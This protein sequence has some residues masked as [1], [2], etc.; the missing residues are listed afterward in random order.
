MSKDSDM[1]FYE[2]W[3]PKKT[4]HLTI[5]ASPSYDGLEDAKVT[6]PNYALLDN[7]GDR[8]S[9]YNI[10]KLLSRRYPTAIIDL[11]S[12]ESL[13]SG[14]IDLNDNL[15]II[16]GPGGDY[17]DNTENELEGNIVCRLLSKDHI[18]S[19]I[20]YS[21]DCEKMM[22]SG[23][24]TPFQS[25]YSERSKLMTLDYGYFS[26]FKN[27][28]YTKTRVIML[29]GIHTLGVLGATRIFDGGE[30][31][32]VN[33]LISLKSYLDEHYSI[34]NYDFETFFKVK[35]TRGWITCPLLE[36]KN[37][38]FFNDT[39][40]STNKKSIQENN[41]DDN[42]LRDTVINLIRIAKNNTTDNI[43]KRSHDQLISMISLIKKDNVDVLTKI[44]NIC[45]KNR[46]IPE[47]YIEEIKTLLK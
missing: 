34:T 12:S 13:S 40:S 18:K 1:F 16:G 3:F 25:E 32:S 5:I 36:K 24:S 26:A 38:I 2:L 4:Q 39:I 17:N 20:S 11:K 28:F 46:N 10:G 42:S 15:V 47:N 41:I 19:K 23:I 37:I 9:I 8:D 6:S 43:R 33:N 21:N 29:H 7:L 22:V 27:P 44:Y 35:V 30:Q 45:A 14:S 31:D